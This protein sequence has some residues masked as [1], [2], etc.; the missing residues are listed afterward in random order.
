MAEINTAE[1]GS[2]VSSQAVWR[3]WKWWL[4]YLSGI[5]AVCILVATLLTFT[6]SFARDAYQWLT[7]SDDIE[8]I[9]FSSMAPQAFLNAGDGEIFY[10]ISM[11]AEICYHR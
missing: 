7:W 8:V 1:E 10:L 11:F 9:T 2:S 6:V 4:P 5:V 3:D